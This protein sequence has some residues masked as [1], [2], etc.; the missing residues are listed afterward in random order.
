MNTSVSVSRIKTM[1]L[2]NIKPKLLNQTVIQQLIA[3]ASSKNKSKVKIFEQQ[4]LPNMNGYLCKDVIENPIIGT[5]LLYQ[6]KQLFMSPYVIYSKTVKKGGLFD[7][8]RTYYQV[9]IK[10]N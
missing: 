2:Q 1:A 9:Y 8:K 6:L 5:A 3:T 7:V 4:E 10:W